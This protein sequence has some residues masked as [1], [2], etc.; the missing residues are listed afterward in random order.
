MIYHFERWLLA[1]ARKLPAEQKFENMTLFFLVVHSGN[2]KFASKAPTSHCQ[3][4]K[5]MIWSWVKDW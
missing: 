1:H 5:F 3:A 2:W 4:F